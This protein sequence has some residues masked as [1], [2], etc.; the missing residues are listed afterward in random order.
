MD[1]DND[2]SERYEEFTVP[3]YQ[4][5]LENLDFEIKKLKGELFIL[6][7]EHTRAQIKIKSKLESAKRDLEKPV[8]DLQ[9]A[10]KADNSNKGEEI[11]KINEEIKK[12][13]SKKQKSLEKMNK[14]EEDLYSKYNDESERYEKRPC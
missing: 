2:Q 4:I 1:A 6:E 12:I 13:D 14:L 3:Q 5:Q 10:E 7:Q 9:K 8:N 11:E